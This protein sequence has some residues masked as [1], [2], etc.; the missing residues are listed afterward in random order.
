M[1]VSPRT[2]AWPGDQPFSCGWT[3]TRSSGASVNLSRLTSSPHVGT[4]V[5]APYHYD[6]AGARVGGLALDAFIGPCVVIDARGVAEI[7][8][9]ALDANALAASP[10]VL[11]R[12]A[13][14]ADPERFRDGFPTLTLDA[15]DVLRRAGVRL[16]GVDAP[17]VDPV[18][19]KD[20]AIHHALGAAGIP[21]VENLVLDGVDAGR[22]ELLAAPVRY[23][24]LDAAPLRAVLRR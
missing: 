14:R 4:H 1:P 17:S 9:E 18:E 6:D 24:D 20:L 13:E 23:V 3:M 21:N 8:A 15:V 12:T 10:R 11:L 19:S 16:V 7:G 5:D 22:Y 2:A